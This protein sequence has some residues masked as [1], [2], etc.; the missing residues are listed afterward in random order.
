MQEYKLCI[1]LQGLVL[2][3]IC[4]YYVAFLV[5]VK[6]VTTLR[7]ISTLSKTT[8]SITT[9]SITTISITTIS[10]T[11]LSITT[12][13]ITTLSITT[14][15]IT[16]LSI[17][18]L[19]ITTLSITTLSIINLFATLSKTYIQLNDTQHIAILTVAY[20]F[21]LVIRL[22]VIMLGAIRLSVI[23]VSVIM[24]SVMALK[25][26]SVSVIFGVFLDNKQPKFL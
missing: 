2:K 11:T 13:S 6:S 9:L 12:L 25:S 18:T 4:C 17:T 24:R 14:L 10:I 5:L 8:L 16:T 26:T 15:S 3:H 23:M 1:I 20:L 19:S 7:S 21:N 22:S